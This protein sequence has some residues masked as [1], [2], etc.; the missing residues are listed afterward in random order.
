MEAF[1]KISLPSRTTAPSIAGIYNKN[2][3]RVANS[4][5]NPLNSPAKIVEP[6]REIPGTMAMLCTIPT[7]TASDTDIFS[8]F[9]RFPKILLD[10][11]KNSRYID[12]P[13]NVQPAKCSLFSLLITNR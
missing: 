2:E 8:G 9:F 1:E 4:G 5:V 13:D 12:E 3:K 7:Q 10:S 6:E 11:Q